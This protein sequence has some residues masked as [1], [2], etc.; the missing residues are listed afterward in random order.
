MSHSKMNKCAL[1]VKLGLVVGA[2]ALSSM[3]AV[4]QQAASTN[5][6]KVEVIE[7][8]GIRAS[9][10]ANL[11][12]KRFSDAVVDVVTAEDIGK[13]PDKNVAESLS[14]ITG[15][16]VSRE[17][18]E[19][20]KITVRGSDPSKNRTLL[21]GQSVATADWFIL[22]SPSRSFNFTLLP[23]ALVNQ[24]EVYK[25]AEANIDEG[26]IGG[27]VIM[28]T[29]KPLDMDAG[30]GA[31]S[32]QGQ[33]SESSGKTDPQLDALYSWK[34]V[35]GNFG[36]L[37]SVS[38]QDRTVQR[39]GLE[40]LGWHKREDGNW[41]PKDI[42]N[43]IFKQDRE[44]TTFFLSSQYAVSDD[45][46]FTLNYMRSEM[47]SNNHNSNFLLRPQNDA[48]TEFSDVKK[49][50]NTVLGATVATAGA[51]EWDLI[52][53]ESSTQTDSI[54][55]QFDYQTTT[56]NLSGSL[57]NTSAEGG[58]YR[59]TSW[60]WEPVGTPGYSFDLSGNKP[61]VNTQADLTN[62]AQFKPGWVW[63]GDKPT[64]DDE[65]YG[66]LDLELPVQL[67]LFTS[68]ETGVKF[69]D[70]ERTQDRHAYSWHGP[71][72][73]TD[74][75]YTDYLAQ[76]FATCPNLS[77]CGFTSGSDRVAEGVISGSMVNQLI[78][79]RQ[80]FMDLAFAGDVYAI[81][82]N[83][84]EIWEIQEKTSAAYV[85]GN[86]SGEGIR[87]NVGVRFVSTK[88]DAGSWAFSGDSWGL[89][90]INRTW[91]APEYLEWVNEDR[92]Y[93][94]VLPSL[95]LAFD[96]TADQILRFSAARVMARPNFQDLA[97]I[98]S[99]G[100]LNGAA[101][102][103]TSGNP[104]LDPQIADQFD[105]SWEY[106][107]GRSSLLAVT[108]FYKDIQSYRTSGTYVKPF[109]NES[110]TRWV[111]V[112]LTR[113]ENGLGGSTDGVEISYQ[114]EFGEFGAIANYTY[115]N[116]TSDQARDEAKAGSGLVE[117][118]SKHMANLT[119]YYE[120]DTFGAR[121]MYNYRTEWY[122]GLHFSGS[123]VYND[124]YGQLDFSAS[125]K[126]TD[127][128]S[129][130]AE[131]INLTDERVEEYN[132]DKARIMSI[133]QNGRRYVLGVNYNF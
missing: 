36:V 46:E 24:L 50:G 88:Q 116:A 55:L 100:N 53:R 34:N 18:G 71:Q 93:S 64:T 84:A 87:G 130:V 66:Q 96:L 60:A 52:N 120:N 49:S 77:S 6:N 39:E 79:N 70:Q 11:N 69:R 98:E 5:D 43:P 17:F 114:Q 8:R 129:V 127:Q 115:T 62:G 91:L 82:D 40:V 89:K 132:I 57:G 12:A 117:G 14:R 20:E 27:T 42:G 105:V 95:N 73:A 74:P 126:I 23:S 86:F 128:L 48:L 108:Y 109:Y 10:E 59:E 28:R 90:T 112:T 21:N 104:N 29:R 7:V 41:A 118:T 119:G 78:H 92:S 68:I 124:A 107:F 30:A 38:K 22:D 122:K 94:E 65:T 3:P 44:R 75:K 9:Q 56:Y 15:V 123:E 26:S 25:S 58:T 51:Y 4:A 83:L 113:P 111:D 54:D 67:G 1:A 37:A 125:Y 31:I 97:P 16:G 72:T 13:F 2:A 63:G 76:M 85:K 33:Y 133:Y 35:E 80:A 45:L 32:L 99:V 47:D 106:Y 121:L 103:G 102:T 81:H 110:Q 101:P 61:T 131:A 19:G